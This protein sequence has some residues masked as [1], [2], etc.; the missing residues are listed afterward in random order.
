M[1]VR[2]TPTRRV[3]ARAVR[4][5]PFTV[6]LAATV[7]ALLLC[8]FPLLTA[9]AEVEKCQPGKGNCQPTPSIPP[10]P[11]LPSASPTPTPDPTTTPD[12]QPVIRKPAPAKPPVAP[13]PAPTV[14]T[15]AP[16]PTA[17]E[18]DSASPTPSATTGFA[19]ASPSH[20]PWTPTSSPT[21]DSNWNKPIDDGKRA[22]QA[23]LVNDTSTS[24]PDLLGILAIMAGVL[25]VGLGGLAFALWSKNRIGTH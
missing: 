25:V 2:P 12:P 4:R 11:A 6:P 22:S 9:H 20:T 3:A 18:T 24:G 1:T 15:P 14:R 5:A 7:L 21:T 23:A 13:A 8:A 16:A 17:E 10:A 19:S